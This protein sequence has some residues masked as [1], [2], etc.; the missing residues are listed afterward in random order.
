MLKSSCICILSP[1]HMLLLRLIQ[2]IVKYLAN[3]SNFEVS[4][5]HFNFVG[6][7]V[8]FAFFGVFFLP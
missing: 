2:S 7:C 5:K 4:F 8:V 6:G 3:Y 1:G